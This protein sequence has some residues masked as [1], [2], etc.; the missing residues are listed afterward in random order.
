MDLDV[1]FQGAFAAHRAG[2]LAD[3]EAGYLAILEQSEHPLSLHNLGV[4]CDAAG[5][6]EEA[7]S[8]YARA[9][10][11]APD[12]PRRQFALGV[13]LRTVRRL[14]EA[15]AAYRRTLALAPDFPKAA[16]DLGC[17]LLAGGRTEEGFRLYETREAR[18]RMLSRT[19]GAPEWTGQ[20][21]A[22]KRLYV[23]REQGLGDQIMMARFL[24]LLGAAQVTYAGP[25]ALRRLFATLGVDFVAA[26][27]SGP[28]PSG[29]DYW[30]LPCSLPHRWGA[31][32]QS[33]PAAPY[34]F[35]R[36]RPTA[37][38]RIGVTVR[39]AADN[40]NDRFRTLSPAA[41]EQ[42]LALPGAISLDPADTG[43][44][45]LQDTADIIAGLDLVVSVDTAVAH[46][47]GAMGRPVW[48]LLARHA[49]DWQWPRAGVSPWYPSARFFVQPRPG[50]WE[51]LVAQVARAVS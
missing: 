12:D 38:G 30:T 41:A 29:H 27:A 11:A 16:F 39:G 17:V 47:A 26:A 36:A 25:E 1:V 15:E 32:A 21:L 35:G 42:L 8:Y 3:A 49:L 24:P 46:L 19:L 50:D 34:L 20:P 22:G 7:G 43:A 33:L 9:A 40:L 10:A 18:A 31:T 5:R 48:V 44:A 45:D 51:A 4:I 23:W 14:D 6:L 37:G 13:H 28:D 2:R